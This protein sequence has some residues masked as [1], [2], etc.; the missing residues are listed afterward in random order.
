MYFYIDSDKFVGISL[1]EDEHH[2]IER[3]AVTG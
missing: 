1:F 3:E 2:L